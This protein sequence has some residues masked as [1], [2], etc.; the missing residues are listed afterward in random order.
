MRTSDI[1]WMGITM[2]LSVLDAWVDAHL[3]DFEAD[4]ERIHLLFEDNTL[5]VQL[6]F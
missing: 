4:K 6:K 3:Y 5:K 2:G 1:W